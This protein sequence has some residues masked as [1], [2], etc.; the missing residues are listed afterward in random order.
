MYIETSS[1]RIAGDI[2]RLVS[3]THAAAP[4]S[5][6]LTFWYHMYGAD[7]GALNIYTRQGGSLG[8][9]IWTQKGDM[10]NR[11]L[12][13]QVTILTLSPFEV[14]SSRCIARMRL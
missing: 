2:A 8:K 9:S 11:W 5:L 3:P 6:C 10:G 7:I 14:R 12:V 13:E 4:K 1:P